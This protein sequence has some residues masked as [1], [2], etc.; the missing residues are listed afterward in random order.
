MLFK[1]CTQCGVEKEVSK[2]SKHKYGKDGLRSSCKSCDSI[3]FKKWLKI[4]KEKQK[5]SIKNWKNKNRKQ[6]IK[7]EKIWLQDNP[8]YHRRLH[9]KKTY[10]ISLEN[11]NNLLK[12]QNGV[13][14]ICGQIEKI[15]NR[16]L[17][18]DHDHVTG[19]IRGLLCYE[20]NTGL[21]KFKDNEILLNKA[22]DYLKKF[23]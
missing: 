2:F 13:C 6:L 22:S 20:C 1:I 14:A 21:G 4:N 8:D 16:S 18:I 23:I 17:S 15:N 12:S 19:K 10:K 9:L 3:D 11:Y 7:T 5:I